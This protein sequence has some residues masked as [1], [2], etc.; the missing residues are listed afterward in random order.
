MLEL[1]V[2]SKSSKRGAELRTEITRE[3]TGD[4]VGRIHEEERSFSV[5][6]ETS[7]SH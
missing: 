1:L 2:P 7:S 3:R 4:V 5:P 6:I